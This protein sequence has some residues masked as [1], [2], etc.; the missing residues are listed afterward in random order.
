MRPSH[1][2]TRPHTNGAP[3]RMRLPHI[4]RP[5]RAIILL[6]SAVALSACEDQ[7]PQEITGS[8]KGGARYSVAVPEGMSLQCPP[9]P[10]V[11][12]RSVEPGAEHDLNGNGVV[13]EEQMAPVGLPEGMPKPPALTTDDSPFPKATTL[14]AAP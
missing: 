9:R 7:R 5:A 10:T 1:L 13:C 8:S 12:A 11:K 4:S 2:D 6:V 3:T 14:S